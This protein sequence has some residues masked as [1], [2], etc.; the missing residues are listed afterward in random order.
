MTIIK[1]ILTL[2][3]VAGLAA[4]LILVT[5]MVRESFLAPVVNPLETS[6][7]A[8][9]AAALR[10]PTPI[11]TPT[12]RIL[13]LSV[14]SYPEQTLWTPDPHAGWLL[15]ELRVNG[16][17]Y[18]RDPNGV[19]ADWLEYGDFALSNTPFLIASNVVD[20]AAGYRHGI[21]LKADGTVWTF[22]NN[23]QGQL[24][25]GEY[26]APGGSAPIQVLRGCVAVASA[27]STCAALTSEGE[28][29]TWG[30]NACGQ[31]G[32]GERGNGAL[33][34]SDLIVPAPRPVLSLIARIQL[35][36]SETTGADDHFEAYDP[37]DVEYVWGGRC[38]DAPT[39]YVRWIEERL[40][41]PAR[42]FWEKINE[43]P[44]SE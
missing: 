17:L 19:T 20:A 3:L 9:N 10:D 22:G 38:P 41:I 26:G 32:N 8:A 7:R 13:Y 42:E 4:A 14:P 6:P 1:R 16:D 39:S 5:R 11:P 40:P 2:A 30:D 35:G 24:G 18:V 33:T 34:E 28:V 31:I 12:P 44:D 37:D 25:N 29:Y 27:H 15:M 21:F 36:A 23:E 43:L